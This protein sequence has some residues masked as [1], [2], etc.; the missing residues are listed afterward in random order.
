MVDGED[1]GAGAI[2]LSPDML[3]SPAAAS[4]AN[5]SANLARARS[6]AGTAPARVTHF[7]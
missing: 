5:S 2:P 3:Q 6:G 1:G 4:V 7:V